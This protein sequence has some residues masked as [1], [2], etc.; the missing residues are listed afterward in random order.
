MSEVSRLENQLESNKELVRQRNLATKLVT[1]P[2]FKELIVDG[3]CMK[4]CARFAQESADPALTHEQRADALGMAQA[5]GHL[6]RY[7]SMIVVMGN[8][9]DNQTSDLEVAIIEARQE[10]GE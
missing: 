10:E 6:R 4:D 5:S 9:A 1:N 2:D 8:T 7:L 3:F